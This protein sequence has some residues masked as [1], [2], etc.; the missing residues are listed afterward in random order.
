MYLELHYLIS[1]I[2]Q[3]GLTERIALSAK[4]YNSVLASSINVN[5]FWLRL[6][7]TVLTDN[8]EYNTYS[9]NITRS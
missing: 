3:A 5:L 8:Y 2:E 9:W 6:V 4:A 7:L 1:I